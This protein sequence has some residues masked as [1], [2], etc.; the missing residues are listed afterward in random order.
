MKNF[1]SPLCLK[2]LIIAESV[3]HD[4]TADNVP[5]VSSNQY[6]MD[7]DFGRMKGNQIFLVKILDRRW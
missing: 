4:V 2:F 5:A 1:S 6:R 3:T 7:M